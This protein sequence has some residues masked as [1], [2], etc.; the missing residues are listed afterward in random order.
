M[1]RIR[2]SGGVCVE[3]GMRVF[4]LLTLLVNSTH[5]LRMAPVDRLIPAA[6]PVGAANPPWH[7][8]TFVYSGALSARCALRLGLEN[9][10]SITPPRQEDGPVFTVTHPFH[11]FFGQHFPL[12]C[13]RFTWGEPRVMFHD[14]T[15]RLRS[16]PTAWTDLAAPDPFVLTAAGRAWFRL[17]DLCALVTLLHDL[18]EALQG[19]AS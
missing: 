18:D 5:Q 9:T 4:C 10:P 6:R 13:E 8:H 14:S 17:E 3:K 16:L 11:P 15:G 1:S 2:S 12:L 7:G 19:G